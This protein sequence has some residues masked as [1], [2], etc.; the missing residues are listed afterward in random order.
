MEL[1]EGGGTRSIPHAVIVWG[2]SEEGRN[3]DA[4]AIA[5]A[6]VCEASGKR[7]CLTCA[8]CVKSAKGIH[9]DI[10]TVE[11]PGDKQSIIV[12]QIRA[13]REDAVVLPN[14]AD[15]KAYIIRRADLMNTQAQN[16]F[17]KLLE[18]PPESSGF[19]LVAEDPASL[20]PTVRSRCAELL[21]RRR[22]EPQPDGSLV[23]D[24]EAALFGG[25]VSLNAFSYALEKL[26]RSSFPDFL[27]G[28]TAMLTRRLRSALIGETSG[29]E[30][31]MKAIR[32]LGRIREY[33]NSNV[34]LG[35]ISGM[36][37]AELMRTDELSEKD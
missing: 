16:A 12:D 25:P 23:S 33:Y 22:D 7:P 11:R 30:H 5:R 27:D 8:H 17:L 15:K 31:L 37:C 29:A 34:S 18:E 21:C 19:I 36:L 26:D 20:L 24:F 10:I 32:V 4:Y 35:H 9:P 2:G 28:A 1:F 3:A 13:I 14:E 6:T